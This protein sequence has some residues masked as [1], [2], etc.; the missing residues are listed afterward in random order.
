M[1]MLNH[2]YTESNEFKYLNSQ[3]DYANEENSRLQA[4]NTELIGIVNECRDMVARLS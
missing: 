4:K 2:N 3:L 1:G